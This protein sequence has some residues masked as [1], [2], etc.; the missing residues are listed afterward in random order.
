MSHLQDQTVLIT[1]GSSGIGLAI[2]SMLLAEGMAVA[3][4]ARDKQKLASAMQF[5][6][7]KGGKLIAVA[8]DVSK[9]DQV[10]DF[11]NQAVDA[12]GRID[13]LVNN[14][15]IAKFN[16]IEALSEEDWDE[17]QNIN[18]KGAFLCTKAVLPVMKRQRSGYIVNIASIA[19]KSDFS[20]ASA[21][22]ASK[23]GMIGLTESLLEEAI[24]HQIRATAIC[25][26]YVATP[27]VKGVPVPQEEM[28][29][30]EDIGKLIVGLLH[31]SP[32]TIIKEIVVN[33][34]G[35]VGD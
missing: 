14:A 20:G 25:P 33:R 12:F 24:Q 15:G 18:L 26:G 17:T 19:G 32:L 21:Y 34:K 35:S 2:A 6:E 11:V 8:T 23:F 29:P 10:A 16:P 5:L 1:G 30:P 7:K 22:C 31:L 27:M 9:A 3:I 4:A 28:I 13:L